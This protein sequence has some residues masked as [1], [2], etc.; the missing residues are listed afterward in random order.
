[1]RYEN[2]VYFNI[3]RGILGQR[4][5]NVN[6]LSILNLVFL[7]RSRI[8]GTCCPSSRKIVSLRA[9]WRNCATD[10]EQP[11]KL[12]TFYRGLVTSKTNYIY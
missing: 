10:S 6:K 2:A 12:T 1:M 4:Y 9:L 7:F 5:K 8:T 3:F 11:S